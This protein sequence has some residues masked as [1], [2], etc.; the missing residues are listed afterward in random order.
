MRSLP[1]CPPATR[2]IALN[3]RNRKN[4]IQTAMYGPANPNLPNIAYWQR[5]ASEWGISIGEAQTMRC[6]NCAAFDIRPEMK[7]CIQEGIGPDDTQHT[8]NAGQLGYCHFFKFKCASART[9]SAWVVGGPI[10]K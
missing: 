8:I 7:K 10:T 3:L 2:D 4:A 5:L 6:G 9:C 1:V